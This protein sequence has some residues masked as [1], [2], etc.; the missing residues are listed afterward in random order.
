MKQRSDLDTG[1]LLFKCADSLRQKVYSLSDH[2][3]NRY[4]VSIPGTEILPLFYSPLHILVHTGKV[5]YELLT[6]RGE[7][8]TLAVSFKY[9]K[10]VLYFYDSIP[11]KSLLFVAIS[12]S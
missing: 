11:P 9:F 4:V 10:G 5:C 8:S 3:G 7:C 12:L 2:H 1:L 6:G